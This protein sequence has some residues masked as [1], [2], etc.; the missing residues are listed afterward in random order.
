VIRELEKR[1]QREAL[2][3]RLPTRAN[4][5]ITAACRGP[6]LLIDSGTQMDSGVDKIAPSTAGDE[7]L[8]G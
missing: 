3:E 6:T 5:I 4:T 1:K 8:P 2:I 7:L